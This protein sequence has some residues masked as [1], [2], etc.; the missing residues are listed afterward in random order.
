MS[1]PKDEQRERDDLALELETVKDLEVDDAAGADSVRG[2]HSADA[3]HC[4][5]EP[6]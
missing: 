4:K 1:N 5:P 3:H 6:D 2:G